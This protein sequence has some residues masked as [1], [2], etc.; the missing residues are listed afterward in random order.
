MKRKFDGLRARRQELGLTL[1]EVGAKAGLS[2]A[3]IRSV[4]VGGQKGSLITRSKIA[5]ALNIPLRSLVSDAEAA[6]IHGL[7]LDNKEK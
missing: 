6:A 4:E 2:S 5:G 3:M 7:V 1:E